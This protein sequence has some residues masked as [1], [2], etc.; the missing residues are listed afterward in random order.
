MSVARDDGR[1][2]V[3]LEG[4]AHRVSVGTVADGLLSG[5]IDG[6]PVSAAVER[7]AGRLRLRRLCR[8]FDFVE[9]PGRDPHS[10]AEHEGHL[11][12]PMPG[13]VLDVRTTV[14][15]RVA[16]GAVLVVLE[17]MKMEHSLVA[18]WDAIVSEVRVK[19]GERVAEG[20]ELVLLAPQDA[21]A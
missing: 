5:S 14:G 6:R 19:A 1:Y 2:R 13:H 8:T 10:S 12:A 20:T 9:T 16:R 21:T 4:A 17:A 3:E 7:E 11:R 18:P 15:A